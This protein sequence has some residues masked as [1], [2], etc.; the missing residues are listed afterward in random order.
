MNAKTQ[1]EIEKRLDTKNSDDKYLKSAIKQN[2]KCFNSELTRLLNSSRDWV[3]ESEQMISSVVPAHGDKYKVQT[4]H[5]HTCLFR[6]KPTANNMN[7][8]RRIR[9]EYR[10]GFDVRSE[11]EKR[12]SSNNMGTGLSAPDTFCTTS[13]TSY[14]F[15]SQ[16]ATK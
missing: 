2:K 7:T 12:A 6:T 1:N 15:T 4:T 9:N 5:K 11:C 10:S 14:K 8:F 3:I 13:L 16:H